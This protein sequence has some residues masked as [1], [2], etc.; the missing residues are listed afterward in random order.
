MTVVIIEGAGVSGRVTYEP[1]PDNHPGRWQPFT[2][3]G[4]ARMPAGE[5]ITSDEL[6]ELVRKVIV[7]ADA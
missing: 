5:P 1:V 6:L 7:G 2:T 4:G 3:A